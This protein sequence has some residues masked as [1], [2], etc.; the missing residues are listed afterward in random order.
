MGSITQTVKVHGKSADLSIGK[1]NPTIKFKFTATTTRDGSTVYV[2]FSNMRFWLPG[3]D[4]Y[5]GYEMKI[6]V[7]VWSYSSSG[8]GSWNDKKVYTK[9]ASKKTWD[10]NPG[11]VTLSS[12]NNR[13]SSITIGVGAYASD[14]K[15]CFSGSKHWKNFSNVSVPPFD[16]TFTITYDAN[17][18]EN[19]PEPQSL[20]QSELPLTLW[21]EAETPDQPNYPLLMQYFSENPEEEEPPLYTD[22]I[23]RAFNGWNCSADQQTYNKGDTYSVTSNCVMSAIWGYAQLSPRVLDDKHVTITFDPR[24]GS[25]A[26]TTMAAPFAPFGYSTEVGGAVQYET[27]TTYNVDIPLDLYP[28]YDGY[29]RLARSAMPTPSRPGYIF[30]DWYSD[31]DYAPEHKV[32]GTFA[33]QT[34]TTIYAKWI[35]I[36]VHQYNGGWEN[37][38]QY[39]WQMKPNSTWVQDAPIFQFD[40]T[41]WVNISES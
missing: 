14:E 13:N 20:R 3:S 23:Y 34:D 25:V 9:S 15:G 11:A 8:T 2:K 4:S 29:A 38:K 27:N 40:G 17:G 24:G 35:P 30:D 16:P 12:T 21:T 1:H 36:P 10:V 31:L 37:T 19:P 5:Y 7:R 28:I 41:K 39:V 22:T 33:T 18:G 26:P 6:Y 32:T